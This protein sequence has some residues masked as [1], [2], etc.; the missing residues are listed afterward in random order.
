MPRISDLTTKVMQPRPQINDRS[1][2]IFEIDPDPI[3]Y[4]HRYECPRCNDAGWLQTGEMKEGRSELVRCSC[5]TDVDATRLAKIDGILPHEREIAFEDLAIT[6][7]LQ[8]VLPALINAVNRRQGFIT[9]HGEDVGTGKSA[10]LKAAVNK[11]RSQNKQAA[12]RRTSHFLQELRNQYE[13]KS[14]DSF[15]ARWDILIDAAVLAIDE[16]EKWQPKEWAIEKFDDLIDDRYRRLDTH[17]TILAGNTL[18]NLT[19]YNH[20]RFHDNNAKVFHIV[21][22]DIRREE[23]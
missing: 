2:R 10:L 7:S 22:A 21:G 13:D 23:R 15:Q 3:V 16:I 19:P 11:A 18:A 1:P 17:L 8:Q 4:P 20:S 6:D 5:K 14:E 12:Y 9:L